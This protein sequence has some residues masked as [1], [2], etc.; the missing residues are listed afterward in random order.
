[1]QLA[2]SAKHTTIR[3]RRQIGE[4][5]RQDLLRRAIDAAMYRRHGAGVEGAVTGKVA[6]GQGA[7]DI[8]PKD[9]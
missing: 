6:N 2:I 4:L 9:W 8:S 3:R 1:M 5:K 7:D